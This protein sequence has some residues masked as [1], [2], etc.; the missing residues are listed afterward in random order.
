[1]V[2]GSAFVLGSTKNCDRTPPARKRA[3]T[4]AKHHFML[5][6]LAGVLE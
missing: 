4:A 5:L 1:M 3:P 2:F 6:L